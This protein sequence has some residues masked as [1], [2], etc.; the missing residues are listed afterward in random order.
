MKLSTTLKIALLC[1]F[2]IT[3]STPVQT[4]T[5]PSATACEIAVKAVEAAHPDPEKDR[6]G[7]TKIG[8]PVVI[9]DD[10]HVWG[11]KEGLPNYYHI[12]IPLVSKER[13]QKYLQPQMD[14]TGTNVYRARLWRI[15]VEDLPV[16]AQTKLQTTGELIIKA[17]AA[18]TGP[19]DYTW[20]QVRSYFRNLLTGADETKNP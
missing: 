9:H 10:G 6:R 5:A 11:S 18:Y 16:A 14:A 17:D 13:V 2:A 1:A 4:V 20:T 7:R 15:R 3:P 8:M 19:Y 12:K